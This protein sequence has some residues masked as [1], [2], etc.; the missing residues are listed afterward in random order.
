MWKIFTQKKE[1]REEVKLQV[2]HCLRKEKIVYFIAFYLSLSNQRHTSRRTFVF[3]NFFFSFFFTYPSNSKN[4]VHK[5]ISA[6]KEKYENEVMCTL[7]PKISNILSNF[8]IGLQVAEN[9]RQEK[10]NQHSTE[11]HN[12]RE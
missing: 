11:N 5:K 4:F 12:L 9:K 6:E 8:K 7:I 10:S 3:F 1:N 2:F